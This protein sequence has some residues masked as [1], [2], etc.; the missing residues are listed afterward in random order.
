MCGKSADGKDEVA[1][2]QSLCVLLQ[3]N[4]SSPLRRKVLFF[5]SSFTCIQLMRRHPLCTCTYVHL[6]RTRLVI[7]CARTNN[8]LTSV[9]VCIRSER[10]LQKRPSPPFHSMV[11]P[12]LFN[13]Q[14][15]SSLNANDVKLISTFFIRS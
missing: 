9:Y 13:C 1:P 6:M 5:D 10:I 2:N 14:I 12:T 4:L 8:Q 7:N 3:S 11:L 15:P